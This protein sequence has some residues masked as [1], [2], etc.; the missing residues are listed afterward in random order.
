MLRDA[1]GLGHPAGEL[2]LRD[3]QLPS[4]L[5][6][7]GN[8]HP[9]LLCV[10]SSV[11]T[12]CCCCWEGSAWV[13]LVGFHRLP[14]PDDEE[15]SPPSALQTLPDKSSKSA[16]L[17]LSLFLLKAFTDYLPLLPPSSRGSSLLWFSPPLAKLPPHCLLNTL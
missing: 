7:L 8:V 16:A 4:L 17:I 3:V 11:P 9:N 5:L 6:L 10:S 1:R 13:I 2:C 14:S 15:L 12:R